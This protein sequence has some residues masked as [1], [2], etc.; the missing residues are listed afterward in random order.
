MN[1]I[2][3]KSPDYQS[4]FGAEQNFDS[5]T[6]LTLNGHA[7]F[8]KAGAFNGSTLTINGILN[9]DE[10][11]NKAFVNFD[12]TMTFAGDVTLNGNAAGFVVFN[13]NETLGA[14][15]K[16]TTTNVTT[17][18][19]GRETALE[20]G[21]KVDF[22]GKTLFVGNEVTLSGEGTF[23]NY[24]LFESTDDPEIK[25]YYYDNG[26][27][28][29]TTNCLEAT[30]WEQILPKHVIS[31]SYTFEQDVDFWY[32]HDNYYTAWFDSEVNRTTD[33]SKRNPDYDHTFSPVRLLVDLVGNIGFS[34]DN[35]TFDKT[36]ATNY[37]FD[38]HTIGKLNFGAN[39]T[40]NVINGSYVDINASW[41]VLT[42]SA[43]EKWDVD[44]SN[45]A[46]D[47]NVDNTSTLNLWL[48]YVSKKDLPN[49]YKT[50]DKTGYDENDK[51]TT[52]VLNEIVPAFSYIDHT[53][54]CLDN[55][56]NYIYNNQ[57][58][59]TG[60]VRKDSLGILV[61]GN[62]E[63]ND[64]DNTGNHT[65]LLIFTGGVVIDKDVSY[66][67]N[68]IV[69]TEQYYDP[70]EKFTPYDGVERTGLAYGNQGLLGFMS[71]SSI[72]V[73]TLDVRAGKADWIY[74]QLDDNTQVYREFE[75]GG[76]LWFDFTNRTDGSNVATINANTLTANDS[77]FVWY[78]GLYKS[79]KTDESGNIVYKDID[80]SV[81]LNISKLNLYEKNSVDFNEVESENISSTLQ[82]LFDKPMADVTVVKD[83]D[84]K[85]ALNV[86]AKT[87]AKF[88]ENLDDGLKK[89]AASWDEYRKYSSY[90]EA[91]ASSED[92]YNKKIDE[93]NS[94][95]NDQDP[96]VIEQHLRNLSRG[97][98]LENVTNMN[99][100]QLGSAGSI[101]WGGANAGTG[102]GTFAN[103]APAATTRGQSKDDK[104]KDA[105]HGGCGLGS[106]L[107]GWTVWGGPSYTSIK[108]NGYGDKDGFSVSRAGF[109]GGLRRQFDDKTSGGFIFAYSS[110]ELSQAGDYT[111]KGLSSIYDNISY[112]SRTEMSDYQLAMHLEH[113]FCEKWEASFFMG[114]G[115]QYLD[116]DRTVFDN[117]GV[118]PASYNYTGATKGNTF[119]FT[120]YL[121]RPIE[122]NKN[123]VLRP[124]IGLDSE[125]SWL[126]GFAESGNDSTYTDL[127]DELKQ[128]FRYDKVSYSRNMGRIGLVAS[129]VSDSGRGGMSGRIFYGVALGGEDAP[130][131]TQYALGSGGRQ[132]ISG[133]A[134]GN[135]SWNLG[136][137]L[138]YY[139]NSEKTLSISA[140]YNAIMYQHA[141]TQNVTAGVQYK[142]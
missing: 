12:K 31:G 27:K 37:N 66:A 139:L 97:G 81:A 118:L 3:A 108:A 9:E 19:L 2:T 21:S 127:S 103:M 62:Q 90:Q 80:G 34:G 130:L 121:A 45:F 57:L 109:L 32:D 122:I 26:E 89:V 59:G 41:P 33:E 4:Y 75:T 60:V 15:N 114:T 58:S 69:V 82:T 119:T 78:E 126:Y 51:Q 79:V 88:A 61:M 124:T 18:F 86:K 84:G 63:K 39:T 17:M 5:T 133:L 107:D 92:V 135:D 134:I 141:T 42:D 20:K 116:W 36:Y 106:L 95:W 138:Y 55:K 96:K 28:I 24:A 23:S 54:Y 104:N 11:Y 83:S 25:L 102:A 50:G 71:G 56:H 123:F 76:E 64:V 100:N 70:D 38:D 132:E 1:T 40:V 43:K 85:Y 22:G 10:T 93:L 142:F 47:F 115:A 7:E 68:S 101:F 74:T 98:G 77:M 94:V 6:H 117:G 65:T 29:E 67:G 137:G 8:T 46:V 120:A 13:D 110:P 136:Y 72:S 87:A 14:G 49:V 53:K 125:H 35:V 140:D 44:S 111:D 52:A 113:V 16:L 105:L 73:D 99:M 112:R 128:R 30:K 91:G 48:P 131:V 129:S